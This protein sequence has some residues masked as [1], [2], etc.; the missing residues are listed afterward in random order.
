MQRVASRSSS[1]AA[2]PQRI[3]FHSPPLVN[4][5]PN[6]AGAKVVCAPNGERRERK[7]FLRAE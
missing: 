2:L 1:C 5:K 6:G 3:I 7:D 4:V